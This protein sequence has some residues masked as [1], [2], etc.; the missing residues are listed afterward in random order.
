[1]DNAKHLHMV[2]AYSLSVNVHISCPIG[3]EYAALGPPPPP[4][5]IPGHVRSTTVWL[6][7]V[8]TLIWPGAGSFPIPSVSVSMVTQLL[9]ALW[10][11]C[12]SGMGKSGPNSSVDSVVFGGLIRRRGIATT[13]PEPERERER[14]PERGCEPPMLQRLPNTREY[15]LLSA[16]T[17]QQIVPSSGSMP[18]S[19]NGSAAFP[20]FCHKR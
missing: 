3:R 16:G 17:E 6:Y 11:L 15:N 7:S 19:T 9:G 2:Y 18:L 8:R 14:E 20:V 1:M 4:P 5:R 10:N 13:W 12:C